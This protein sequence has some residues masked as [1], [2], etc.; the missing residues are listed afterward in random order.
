MK[1]IIH[2]S[3]VSLSL[4]QFHLFNQSQGR[5]IF[6]LFVPQKLG[7]LIFTLKVVFFSKSHSFII[8]LGTF[9]LSWPKD[10]F[11]YY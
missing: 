5:K 2:L 8:I 9:S 4:S 11:V 7:T 3:T 1:E 6:E 10:Q